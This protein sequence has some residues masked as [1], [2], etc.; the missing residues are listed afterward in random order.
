MDLAGV[1][2]TGPVPGGE[3]VS[4]VEQARDAEQSGNA[5]QA[6]AAERTIWR[7]LLHA[8][9]AAI[10][11][12]VGVLLEGWPDSLFR[13]LT[14][15]AAA[16][17]VAIFSFTPLA[18]YLYT[19]AVRGLKGLRP[20]RP[21]FL[22]YLLL[23]ALIIAIAVGFGR[24]LVAVGGDAAEWAS[25]RISGCPPATELR[26]LTSAEG[27]TAAERLADAYTR[28]TA[29]EHHDCPTVR[30]HVYAA[31]AD[32]ATDA[33]RSGWQAN[34][35]GT[36]GPRPDIWLPDA[37]RHLLAAPAESSNGLLR[38]ATGTSL[39]TTPIVLA[40]PAA[41]LPEEFRAER[42]GL[43]WAGALAVLDRLGRG[44]VRPDP[45]R[46]V[47]GE[48]ATVAMYASGNG[49]PARLAEAGRPELTDPVRARELE[50]RL[51]EALDLGGYPLGDAAD[52][53]CRQ[54]ESDARPTALAITEQQLVQYN[55]GL[56]LGG[57]CPGAAPAPPE[58]ALVAV[59]P[60]DT[61]SLDQPL[62]ELDWAD[63]SAD[64]ADQVEA[65]Q[66]WL[67]G[68]A[69]K[70]ALVGV[71]LR[72]AGRPAGDP[73]IERSGVLPGV[74]YPRVPLTDW[75]LR[76]A[77][78]LRQEAKRSGR[79]LLLLDASGSMRAATGADGQTRFDVAARGVAA[80]AGR[81]SG[82]DEF[83]VWTFQGAGR[84]P[85]PLVPIGGGARER[86][87]VAER[88]AAVR[89]DG[90]TPL[91]RAVVAGVAEV[92]PTGP[93]QMSALVVLT[94][95][96]EEGSGTTAAQMMAAARS[97]GVRVF[98]V[99]VGAGGC[100]GGAIREVTAITAGACYETDLASL[101]R[102][103]GTLFNTLWGGTDR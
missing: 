92:G 7:S 51:A 70:D 13:W 57:R 80:L 94:D 87:L 86:E 97:S 52:L 93:D 55:T 58:R 21:L 46:S 29:R 76:S 60:T 1:P 69:G 28:H 30:L 78:D 103:L 8:F 49:D 18:D 36:I 37:S 82:R 27:L 4:D 90:A 45:A 38:S 95:G 47:T 74:A 72:P 67:A 26:V 6:E 66:R 32:E 15:A 59:Y 2:L 43:D 83:G 62:V 25:V 54:R 19:A 23:A 22:R 99:A 16:L 41:E 85:D 17:I 20:S 75:T 100:G 10:G 101:D 35:L 64:Q 39:A 48:Y 44:L 12:A 9:L 102:R 53:L 11:A 81:M 50:N 42:T 88:L 65:F 61:L 40:V 14:V 77:Q 79:V 84:P 24:S 56:P 73:L 33:L 91:Y 68:D 98:V 63:R 71:G 3:A 5:E 89:P 96:T 34:S 31:A